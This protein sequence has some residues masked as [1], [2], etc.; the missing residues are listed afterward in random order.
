MTILKNQVEFDEHA[1]PRLDVE[2]AAAMRNVYA[3]DQFM[4]E[5]LK[6]PEETMQRALAQCRHIRDSQDAPDGYMLADLCCV[7]AVFAMFTDRNPLAAACLD[8]AL[9]VT[10]HHRLAHLMKA[11]LKLGMPP[12]EIAE[13]LTGMFPQ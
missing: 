3:R 10:P 1:S 6:D 4:A 13:V 7:A 8:R 11:A 12:A 5:H 2:L 9:R